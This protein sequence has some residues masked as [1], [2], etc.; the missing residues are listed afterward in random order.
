ML[1][2]EDRIQVRKKVKKTVLP[3][4]VLDTMIIDVH[5]IPC[6][7]V[8]L[9]LCARSW[10]TRPS[11]AIRFR[12]YTRTRS[13]AQFAASR[14]VSRGFRLLSDRGEKA[15]RVGKKKG[16]ETRVIRE[17]EKYKGGKIRDRISGFLRRLSTLAVLK[18]DEKFDRL[19]EP[20]GISSSESSSRFKG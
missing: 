3:E 4:T 5:Y 14:R 16:K 19:S 10:L 17:G 2:Y 9:L 1:V 8:S 18:L 12:L 15:Q 7:I 6:Y 20:N 13:L 11:R